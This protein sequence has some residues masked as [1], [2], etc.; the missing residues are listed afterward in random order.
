MSAA[1]AAAVNVVRVTRNGHFEPFYWVNWHFLRFF[2]GFSLISSGHPV[3]RRP[4]ASPIELVFVGRCFVLFLLAISVAWIPVLQKFGQAQLFVYVQVISNF[5]Q[6]PIAAVFV[7]GIIWH[8][9]TEPVSL[10]QG[11]QKW[12][13]WAIFFGK[14]A[15][16]ETFWPVFHQFHLVTLLFSSFWKTE[17]FLASATQSYH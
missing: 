17:R 14:L 2:G 9:V 5:F 10:F 7:L 13:F 12:S 15:F 16:L 11:D 6:P 8:R 1:A 4:N 3:Y